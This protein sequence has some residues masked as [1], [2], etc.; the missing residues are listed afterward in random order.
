MGETLPCIGGYDGPALF[1]KNA[2]KYQRSARSNGTRN[3][4]CKANQRPG[5]NVGD[6]QIEW[7]RI[8]DHSGAHSRRGDRAHKR[9]NAVQPRI[10]RRNTHC[11]RIDVRGQY[12]LSQ[13]LG[14]AD[15]QNTA[16]GTQIENVPWTPLPRE[17]RDHFK[18]ACGGAVV[19]G[20]E[21]EPGLDLD[22]DQAGPAFDAI[23]CAMNKKGTG[24]DWFQPGQRVRDPVDF[25]QN[26][27]ADLKRRPKVPEYVSKAPLYARVVRRRIERY[28][29]DGL[30]LVHL[31][32]RQGQTI[33]LERGVEAGV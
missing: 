17:P 7:R 10:G 1:G 12:R 33:I 20:T 27:G 22:R 29:V 31:E 19:A 11:N 9:G 13:K 4:R 14:G 26:F 16:A 24:G 6:H 2:G 21:R 30:R 8:A 25:R 28:F 18:A 32:N 23:M 15:G 5:K 3:G